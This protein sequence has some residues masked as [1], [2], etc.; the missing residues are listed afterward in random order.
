M[1][2]R[3]T[4]HRVQITGHA[5]LMNTQNGPRPIADG[6]LN[7]LGIHVESCRIDVD[8]DGPCATVPNSVRRRDVRMADCDDFVPGTHTSRQ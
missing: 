3:N 2:A 7:S 5:H 8:K 1:P 4:D 6:I